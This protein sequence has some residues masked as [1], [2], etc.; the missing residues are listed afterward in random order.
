LLAASAK[1]RASASVELQDEHVERL[2]LN[3]EPD[4]VVIQVYITSARRAYAIAD[5]YR[6]KGAHVALGDYI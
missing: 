3:D 6:K 1:G 5:H 4:L 2:D